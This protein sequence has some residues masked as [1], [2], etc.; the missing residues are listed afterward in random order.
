MNP[1]TFMSLVE[2]FERLEPAG[3][4]QF[5]LDL[6][7]RP[8][9]QAPGEYNA[10]QFATAARAFLERLRDAGLDAVELDD[11]EATLDSFMEQQPE[12]PEQ[13]QLT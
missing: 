5:L 9:A 2:E 11:I 3:A 13:Q 8:A 12:E 4:R 10:D 1:G 7:L 6:V